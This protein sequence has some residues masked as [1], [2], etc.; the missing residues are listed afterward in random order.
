MEELRKRL[1]PKEELRN[2]LEAVK[3]ELEKAQSWIFT[4]PEVW[5]SEFADEFRESISD[6]RELIDELASRAYEE[7]E[8]GEE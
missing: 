7:A 8:E 2:S 6:I 4:H 3:S 1:T 5:S